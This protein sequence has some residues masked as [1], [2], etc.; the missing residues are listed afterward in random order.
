VMVIAAATETARTPWS[1]EK[2][3]TFV[4][5]M[6]ESMGNL[7]CMLKGVHCNKNYSS[8]SEIHKL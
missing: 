6:N 8:K 5:L 7:P 4:G 2:L 1:P 3:K